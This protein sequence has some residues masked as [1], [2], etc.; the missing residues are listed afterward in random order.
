VAVLAAA[1]M[2]RATRASFAPIDRARAEAEGVLALG[3]GTRLT[4]DAPDEIRSLLLAVN[5]LLDRLDAAGAAQA[6]FT[7][8]AAHELR[9]PVAAMV[10]EL[11]VALRRE[12]GVGELREALVSAR[13]EAERLRRIVQALTAFARVDAGEAERGREVAH[14]GEIAARALAA[15][16]GGLEAAGNTV[17]VVVGEDPT[18]EANLALVELALANLLLNA[19]RHAPGAAV[20]L[21][22]GADGDRAVFEVHDAGPGVPEAER[23]A[24]FTRFARAG[25]AR[26]DDAEGLGLGLPFAREVA[27]RHGGDCVLAASPLGGAMVR[28]TLPVAGDERWSLPT[29]ASRSPNDGG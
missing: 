19:A 9:T 5:G 1:A 24:M 23:E 18:V 4:T 7:A 20:E 28:L 8:E 27:R 22:V 11:D 12:R 21:R 6:R 2:V 13:E 14:A 25:R 26:R 29:S 16:R 15:E 3:Q 10:G 17:A